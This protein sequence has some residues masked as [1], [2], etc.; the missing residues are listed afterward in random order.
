MNEAHQ[1]SPDAFQ[2]A[3]P[4]GLRKTVEA[5]KQGDHFLL[6]SHIRSDADSIG[7]ELG[8][9]Y[10]LEEL[11]RDYEIANHGGIDPHLRWMPGADRIQTGIE[12]DEASRETVIVLDCANRERLASIND[13]IS[14]GTNLVNIDHH[15]TNDRFGTINWIEPAFS[16][17][18]EMVYVLWN[19]FQREPDARAASC[20]YAALVADTGQFSFPHTSEQAHRVAAQL[21]DAGVDPYEI[22]KRLF[23]NLDL[24]E[25]N[26]MGQIIQDLKQRVDGQLTWA[27]LGRETYEKCGTEPWESQPFI[28]VLMQLKE[29]EVGLLLRDLVSEDVGGGENVRVKG[30]LRSRGRYNVNEIAKMFGGGGHPQAAGFLVDDADSVHDVEE[31]VVETISRYIR[32]QRSEE[33]DEQNRS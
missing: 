2:L 23:Q 27:T 22:N 18:G 33:E 32:N 19:Q 11:D 9:G 28:Q 12:D 31:E 6:S 17:V 3:D 15:K 26:L 25:L 24:P 13:V 20:M 4:E 10:L 16:S 7:S 8:L 29:V 1:S 5:I 14:E 21:L 30:S